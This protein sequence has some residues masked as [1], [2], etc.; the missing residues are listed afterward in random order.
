MK[1]QCLLVAAITHLLQNLQTNRRNHL[2]KR[3]E[4]CEPRKVSSSKLRDGN[5]RD[6]CHDCR[7]DEPC[8]NSTE[9]LGAQIRLPVSGDDL[10]NDGL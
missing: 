7:P 4:E 2:S 6:V 1:N 5:F 8:S 9:D 3:E 10:E